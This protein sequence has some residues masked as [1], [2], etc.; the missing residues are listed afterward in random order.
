M[1]VKVKIMKMKRILLSTLAGC[2]LAIG[3]QAATFYYDP[4][5]SGKWS[6]ASRWK[7]NSGT[8]GEKEENLE[9]QRIFFLKKWNEHVY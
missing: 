3:V 5:G 2:G 7:G 1:V 9:N 6:D 8:P 4:N